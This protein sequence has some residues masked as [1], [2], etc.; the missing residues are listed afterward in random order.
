[1]ALNGLNDKSLTKIRCSY[2]ILTTSGIKAPLAELME[3][4][5]CMVFAPKE[6]GISLLSAYGEGLEASQRKP[7][8]P[9][10]HRD[11]DQAQTGSQSPA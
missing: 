11:R 5:R 6:M 8:E 10:N 1:M 2:I 7:T 4:T 9:T 3:L